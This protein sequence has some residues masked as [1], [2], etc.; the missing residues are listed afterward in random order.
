MSKVFFQRWALATVII[1]VC[2]IVLGAYV[3][4]SH[5]GLGCPDW[6]GCY[7]H[8][9]WPNQPHEVDHAESVWPER[10]V[11]THKAAKEMA[12]RYLVGVLGPMIVLL[13]VFA[14]RRRHEAGQPLLIPLLA[15]AVVIF[16]AVLGMWTV[17][18]KLKPLVV[19]AHLLGGMSTFALLWWTWLR[20]HDWRAGVLRPLALRGWIILG[21]VLVGVQIALG[22]WVST[23]YAALACP[24]FPTCQ[25]RWWPAMDFNEAFVL[26]R[27]IGV[28]YE[29]GVL[30]APARAAIHVVHRIGA[31]V[32][33]SYLLWLG[34]RL[35]RA[36]GR[37]WAGL[38]V[39]LLVVQ[40]A[41]GIGNVVFGLPL[42]VATAHNGVAALLLGCLLALLAASR[43]DRLPT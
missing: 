30:D 1:T 24:D 4:L 5:A 8:I 17:T 2:V 22:G 43:Q 14:W 28:D 35:W 7:G 40:V 33:A 39:G 32:V 36:G 13:A 37:G 34:W 23:N 42:P 6:P 26:W 12:H 19:T 20:V 21:L 16:Q 27:G 9:T 3:R 25:G 18:W 15:V 38:L 31:I 29:G 10:P 41:L 11:E